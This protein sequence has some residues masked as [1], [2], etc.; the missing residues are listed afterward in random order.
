LSPRF[1]EI[2]KKENDHLMDA[3]RYALMMES[4]VKEQEYAIRTRPDWISRKSNG[5]LRPEL[6]R[7][8]RIIQT[9][10]IWIKRK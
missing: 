6:P 7:D 9:R 1:D 10:P 2:P 8:E 5:I 3:L 4:S